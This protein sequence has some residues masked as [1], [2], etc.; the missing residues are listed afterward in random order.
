MRAFFDYSPALRVLQSISFTVLLSVSFQLNHILN[1]VVSQSA[2]GQV[3]LAH[4][5]AY[6]QLSKVKCQ[7]SLLD[8]IQR[9]A[10]QPNGKGL[11]D[12][13]PAFLLAPM[14]P[15]N[16]SIAGAQPRR[17]FQ[18]IR[19]HNHIIETDL[20]QSV[21]LIRKSPGVTEFTVQFSHDF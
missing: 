3:V 19:H 7:M 20:V 9:F 16:K 10:L 13:Q 21:E 8:V 17:F 11:C 6:A 18:C 4:T 5:A 12:P 15:E 1:P 2:A 14:T